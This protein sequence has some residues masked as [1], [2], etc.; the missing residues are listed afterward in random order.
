M[1]KQM[2]RLTSCLTAATLALAATTASAQE[3][4]PLEQ[5]TAVVVGQLPNGLTYIIR[6]NE[7]PKGTAEFYIAQKVGA[8]LEEDDQN[9]LA[10]FLEHMAFNGTKNF[11]DKGIINCL[12]RV[13]VRFGENIN[14]AT[15]LDQT[16][17]NLSAVPT[18]NPAIV[19][20]ALL[21]L[22]DWSGFISLE[23]DEIDKE[24][25]VI[26]EEWRTRSSAFRRFYFSHMANTLPGTRYAVRNIIG[27]TAVINN[28]PHEAIRAYYRKWYRPDLQGVVI[29]GDIDPKAIEKRIAQMWADIPAPVNPAKREYAD[30]TLNDQPIF[31]IVRDKEATMTSFQIQFRYKPAPD[32]VRNSVQYSVRDVVADLASSVFNTRMADL[33]EKG[34]PFTFARM[35]ETQYIPSLNSTL[36][37]AAAKDGHTARTMQTVLDEIEKLR[38]Y[39]V[40]PSELQ[41]AVDNL[42]KAYDD[43]YENRNKVQSNDYVRRY[44]N[45]F[46]NRDIITSTA[47]DRDLAH[48]IAPNINVDLVN[49]FIADALKQ[50]PVFLISAT[51]DDDGVKTP[52]QYTADL[53]ALATKELQPYKDQAADTRLVDNDPKPG[54][55]KK[56]ADDKVYGS[57]IA[58]LS[59]GIRVFLLP[60]KHEDNNIIL[61][62]LSR[63]G[64]S[65]MPA[66]MALSAAL[67]GIV[68]TQMGLGKFSSSD[69]RKALTGK[70][71]DIYNDIDT[72]TESIGAACSNADFETMLQLVYLNFRP[73][74]VDTLAYN[75]LVDSYRSY[76]A[77]AY[78][79]PDNIFKA[80]HFD[81]TKNGNPYKIGITNSSDL[82]A[83]SLDK[84]VKAQQA[85]FSSARGFDFIIVGSFEIDSVMPAVCKWLGALPTGKRTAQWTRRDLYM[86]QADTTCVFSTPMTTAKLTFLRTFSHKR[87]YDRREQIALNILK[88]CL[89][90][91]YLESIREEQGGTYGVSVSTSF[92]KEPD[93]E[94]SLTISFDTNEEIFKTLEPLIT[95]EIKDIAANG[96]RPDDLDKVK[97]NL[98]K[99]RT[100]SL[101]KNE[102]W[103]TL[104]ESLA[105]L[106]IDDTSYQEFVNSITPADVQA[107]A[108]RLVTE[109]HTATLIMKGSEQ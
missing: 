59:N 33:A 3:L 44:V 93:Q 14:A 11:P 32:D 72:Y 91:R 98:V 89:D 8:V 4:T 94:Y 36:F 18:A 13:G 100:E 60:T 51:Q 63:G 50:Q 25:G 20:S 42:L 5:D 81:L 15:G 37:I 49:Q 76:L 86:P 34:A 10:H 77:N 69:L 65:T 84:V 64:F 19:D 82:D 58:T 21:I 106:G 12:E 73:R 103:V 27:D 85:R 17:Y 9:G 109:A 30:I 104:L 52:E 53:K 71:V 83:L 45:S 39:G 96:P 92:S 41:R 40:T 56:W 35:G 105:L 2:K 102:T 90:I 43:E 62:A 28:F 6:H 54:K 55:V 1:T 22:H 108:R 61:S 101:E 31:S 79:D 16:V 24:R 68:T 23:A 70:S 7:L 74:H 75:S 38:R 29:V 67:S 26:R 78:K 97:K 95:R 66:D 99:A 87:K 88:R 48:L 46:L 57:R 107:W 47:Y 80:R